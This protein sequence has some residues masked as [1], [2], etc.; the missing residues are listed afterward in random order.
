MADLDYFLKEL[1]RYG[2]VGVHSSRRFNG[3]DG[4]APQ[5]WWCKV[6][7][8]LSGAGVA[9]DVKSE[10][11]VHTDP[12]DAAAECYARLVELSRS[13]ARALPALEGGAL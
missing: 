10:M 9:A 8:F 4:L 12:R 3:S 6:E 11:G 5:T 1:S 7:L 2:T 13:A